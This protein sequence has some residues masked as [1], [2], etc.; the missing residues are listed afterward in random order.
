MK[1]YYQILGLQKSASQDEIKKA[2]RTLAHKYHPDKGGDEKKFKEI[3]EAYQTLSNQEKRQQYDTFGRTFEG[4]ADPSQGF[5][6]DFSGFRGGGF[7]FGFEDIGDIFGEMFGFGSQRKSKD[8]KRGED[9]EIDMELPLEAV[10]KNQEKEIILSKY[11]SCSRCKGSGA[12]PGTKTK[13]CFTCRG[14]GRVQKIIKTPLGSF[15]SQSVCPECGGEGYVPEKPCNVCKGEGRIKGEET[16]KVEIPAGVDTNQTLKF[17][18]KGDAARKQGRPG[19]LYLRIFV[20]LHPVFERK[21]DD[22]YL[23][24][25]IPFSKAVLGGEAEIE[26][27]EKGSIILEIPAGTESEKVF[28]ISG[29]GLTRFGSFNKRGDLYVKI[30]IR[31]PKKVSKR[32]KDLLGELDK[33]GL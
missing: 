9:I 11:V 17:A 25:E 6:F 20:K 29:K 2:Y 13:E 28:R 8:A 7:D 32:Q 5:G 22:L 1:D 30:K 12:E 4:G 23:S 18:G 3:N 16:V 31:T 21:G 10:L 33:E 24:Q 15:T 27:L 14:A 19:N 26:T